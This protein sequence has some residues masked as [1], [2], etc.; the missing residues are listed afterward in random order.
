MTDSAT[1]GRGVQSWGDPDYDEIDYLI[2]SDPI[3]LGQRCRRAEAKAENWRTVADRL[4]DA[5]VG[6]AKHGTHSINAAVAHAEYRKARDAEV[7]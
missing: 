5:I 7:G 2:D 4:A 3:K 1:P 6:M